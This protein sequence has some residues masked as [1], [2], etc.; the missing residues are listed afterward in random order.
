MAASLAGIENLALHYEG[1]QPVAPNSTLEYF[2][3][4]KSVT[5]LGNSS[6]SRLLRG[7]QELGLV[8]AHG[9]WRKQWTGEEVYLAS[10]GEDVRNRLRREMEVYLE[11]EKQHSDKKVPSISAMALEE[12]I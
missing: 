9:R 4:R 11:K 3:S 2:T 8:P 5:I 12:R 1:I 7:N 6:I 10:N